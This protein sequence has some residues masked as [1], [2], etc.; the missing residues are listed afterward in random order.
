IHAYFN[1]QLPANLKS[2]MLGMGCF[3]GAERKFWLLENVEFTE[4]GYAGGSSKNP[5][6]RD[7]CT[8]RTGHAEVVRVHYDPSKLPLSNLLKVFWESHDP[9]QSNRQGNDHGSQYRSALFVAD[10]DQLKLANSSC[11]AY[12]KLLTD[13]IK[14]EIK[15]LTDFHPAEDYHQQYL[16]K[17][18]NGY[19]GLRGT[20][21]SCPDPA[22]WH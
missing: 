22:Q 9:T 19:C 1:K 18:P 4:V 13:S 6:Y 5:N 12:Q 17:N 2:V 16:V 8:G 15:L 11:K 20:G 14:T 10:E 21:I 3:W 7:V